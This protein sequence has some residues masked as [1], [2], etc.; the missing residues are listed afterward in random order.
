MSDHGVRNPR[1]LFHHVCG[2]LLLSLLTMLVQASISRSPLSYPISSN[3]FLSCLNQPQV[4]SSSALIFLFQTVLFHFSNMI[5]Y[6]VILKPVLMLILSVYLK[7]FFNFL[8]TVD[9]Q[10]IISVDIQYIVIILLYDLQCDHPV[11]PV[12]I[13]CQS[14]LEY[15]NESA[16]VLTSICTVQGE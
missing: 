12:P 6:L 10:Y 15:S 5:F 2:L 11:S 14:T 13:S 3:K 8:L 16:L 1:A 7:F 9:I 4:F